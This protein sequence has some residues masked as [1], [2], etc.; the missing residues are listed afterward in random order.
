MKLEETELFEL[1]SA[2]ADFREGAEHPVFGKWKDV[3]NSLVRMKYLVAKKE[4]DQHG[5]KTTFYVAG[6]RVSVEWDLART[7]AMVSEVY[8]R[9]VDKE[10]LKE[11]ELERGVAP[12]PEESKRAPTTR[13]KKAASAAPKAKAPAAKKKKSKFVDSDEEDEGLFDDEDE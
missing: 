9:P 1:A 2:V 5:E 12:V 11:L 4:K 6:P 3:I 13:A 7:E 8:G 10:K